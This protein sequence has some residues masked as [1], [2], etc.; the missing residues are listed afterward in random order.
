MKIRDSAKFV[1]P[2]KQLS[3]QDTII[4]KLASIHPDSEAVL[5]DWYDGGSVCG[6]LFAAFRKD[7]DGG[8][9]VR[10]VHMDLTV[11]SVIFPLYAH[12]ATFRHFVTMLDAPG[13]EVLGPTNLDTRS[14]PQIV[15]SDGA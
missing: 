15:K 11:L 3:L 10:E 6:R 8:L 9:F 14:W 4:D 13:L 7:P 1:A 5:Q 12:T 2:N